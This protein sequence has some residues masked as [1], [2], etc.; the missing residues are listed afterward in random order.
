MAFSSVEQAGCQASVSGF[1]DRLNLP[2]GQPGI[3]IK[4][5]VPDGVQGGVALLHFGE[6]VEGPPTAGH[7]GENIQQVGKR[8]MVEIVGGEQEGHMRRALAGR[9]I[10]LAHQ[11]RFALVSRADAGKNAAGGVELGEH[12]E[13]AQRAAAGQYPRVFGTQH[14]VAEAV[15]G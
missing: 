15:K 5:A 7:F 8:G 11:G 4:A 10:D 13:G 6:Q 12:G 14:A 9:V 2:D 3:D 1:G